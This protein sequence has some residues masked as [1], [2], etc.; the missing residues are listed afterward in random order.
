MGRGPEIDS[1]R[2]A[3]H[4][5]ETRYNEGTRDWH[6]NLFAIK[7]FRYCEFFFFIYF[8]STGVKEIVRYTDDFVI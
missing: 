7:R 8:T 4:T 1:E 5:E 6:K 2:P 3:A